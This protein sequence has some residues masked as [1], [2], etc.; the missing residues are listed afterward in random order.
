MALA[1]VGPLPGLAAALP[2][3]LALLAGALLLNCLWMLI[4]GLTAFWFES[5]MPFQ[6]IHQK[7]VF[8]LGGM[9]F[10]LDLLPPWLGSVAARLPFAFQA[11]WPARM[12]VDPAPERFG[13]ALLGTGLYAM[14]LCVLAVALFRTGM[15]RVQA[16]GG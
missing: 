3:G 6:W 11:Y 8:I 13:D 1:L 5:V 16:H 4:I 7:L 15:R 12:L 9:L 10:P 2:R 14:A